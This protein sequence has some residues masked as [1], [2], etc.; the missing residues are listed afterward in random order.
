MVLLFL[1]AATEKSTS[2]NVQ[3][4]SGDTF[5]LN[6]SGCLAYKLDQK[7]IERNMLVNVTVFIKFFIY[8]F[9]SK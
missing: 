1:I 7:I 8:V 3:K 5:T 4:K 6:V 9:T 2:S